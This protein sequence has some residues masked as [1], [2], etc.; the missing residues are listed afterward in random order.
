MSKKYVAVRMPV[1][2]YKNFQEK[3]K[4]MET[5]VFKIIRKVRKIPLTKVF[6]ATSENPIILDDDYL[7]KLVK[8]KIK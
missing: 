5:T 6:I 1:E 7:M 4:K 8:K 2:A 3:Q